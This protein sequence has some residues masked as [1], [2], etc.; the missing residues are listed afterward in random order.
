MSTKTLVLA[1]LLV[2]TTSAAFTSPIIVRHD[3]DAE[4]YLALG[5]RYGEALCHVRN[6][7]GIVNA[8]GTL[9][10][11]RWVATAAHVARSLQ[12]GQALEIG[13]VGYPIDRVFMQPQWRGAAPEHDIAL[14]RLQ[15]AVEAV[16]PVP[17]YT[18]DD[19]AGQ[20]IILAGAGM[21]GT[22]LTGPVE[23][24]GQIRGATN[25]ID[26]AG[27]TW[28]RFVFDAPGSPTTT[29]LEGVSGPGDSGGPAFIVID[30]T[31][32]L[33]GISSGQDDAATD[34]KPGRY[35][36]SEYYTRVSHYAAWIAH[37]MQQDG[38][39]LAAQDAP[40]RASAASGEGK[41][42]FPDSATGRALKAL[43]TTIDKGDE[44]HTRAFVEKHF[45]EGFLKGFT[46]EEH[47]GFFR[48]LHA[49][50]PGLDV[51]AVQK[52]G[53]NSAE[54]VLVSGQERQKVKGSFELEAAP[55][56]RFIGLGFEPVAQ[57]PDSGDLGSLDDLDQILKRRAEQNTF[58]GVVLIA[59]DSKPVF[60]NAYGLASKRFDVPNQPDTKFNL[61]S[62]NKTFTAV[63]ILQLAQQGRLDLDMPI[64]RYVPGLPDEVGQTVT[65]RHLL[66][67]RSG[68][69]SYWQH[70]DYEARWIHLRRV[71]DYMAFI[72][73]IPL[74]FAPGARQ[75]YSNTGY[76]VLGAIVEA[77]SG[78]DYYDYVRANIY[79]PA[80]MPST[81]AYAMDDPVKNL[82]IGYTNHNPFV[83][84][85][86]D[87]GFPR[88]NLF[89][90]SVKGT[91]AG[92]GYST[93]DDLLRFVGALLG[94]QLLDPAY[95]RLL[96]NRFD[97][98]AAGRPAMWWFGGGA[99]GINAM[100][101]VDLEANQTIIVLSNY[102]SP[103]ARDLVPEIV[104]ML[105]G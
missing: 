20:E 25:R 103:T 33:A 65:S 47:V 91:P 4:S 48:E 59:Q 51:E 43:L 72:K 17:L 75:Q 77:V 1:A 56:H 38:S 104:A 86:P 82:A 78:E 100:V 7:R 28:L 31:A 81:D 105:E 69:G 14:V 73:D 15:R 21:R 6:S 84:G 39:G 11:P 61:G 60:W 64:G 32:Y 55:P 16:E 2:A 90:H 40:Q 79:E 52:T 53:P 35:G 45:E 29:D 46:M 10:A 68:W 37:V 89:Q 42:Q 54:F 70:P 8:G 74:D 30:G 95:T 5:K 85:V 87:T 98:D 101:R 67:H 9:I 26:E 99:E 34:G 92:G 63:A 94:H 13:G 27:T 23:D 50:L 18:Q 12:P 71:A 66:Q 22:G 57:E 76:L 49:L 80:G 36:V 3:R 19:E 41:W 62:S 24:D 58:S 44:A 97:K 102:D 93:A 88:N 96:L 83:R